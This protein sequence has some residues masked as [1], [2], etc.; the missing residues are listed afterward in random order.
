MTLSKICLWIWNIIKLLIEEIRENCLA[1]YVET[2]EK[3]IERLYYIRD[4]FFVDLTVFRAEQALSLEESRDLSFRKVWNVAKTFGNYD[5]AALESEWR[6][7][8]TEFDS[9]P[10]I[11]LDMLSFDEMWKTILSRRGWDGNAPF[12][13]L[14]SLVGCIRSL[15]HSNASA[16]RTFSLLP[17]ISTKK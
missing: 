7:L 8:P 4:Q 14:K 6:L 17:N 9:Q 16:E 3:S 2:V 15:S 5:K 13:L 1:F 10:G 12:P 11:P